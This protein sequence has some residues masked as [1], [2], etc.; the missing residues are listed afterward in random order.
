ME[1]YLPLMSDN[2]DQSDLDTVIEFLKGMPRLTQG[3]NVQAFEREWS[4]WLGVEHS[5]FVNSGSSANLLTMAALKEIYGPGEVIVPPLTWNSD[6]CSVMYAGHTPVFADINWRTLALDTDR[7]LEKITDRTRAVFITHVLGYNGLTDRLVQELRAR[8]IPLIEDVCE[9][10]GATFK[11]K[12]LGTYGLASNFSYYFAHHM[13]TIE[14][15]MI[16]TDDKR[17][18][19]V[20]RSLRGHG[21]VRE[22]TDP[23]MKESYKAEF[24]D[25]NPDFIFAYPAYNCRSTEINAVIGR[26]QLKRLDQNNLRRT[27]NFNRFIR[28]LDKDAYYTD[29]DSEGSVNYAFTLVLRKPD[30]ALW[31]RIESAL[32]GNGIEFRRGLSGGGNQLRQPY[33]RR[34]L[35]P[36]EHAKHPVVEHMH[37]YSCYIGNYPGLEPEKIDKL[38]SI[39]NDCV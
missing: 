6:V 39:L 2:I 30:G 34:I 31:S 16:C 17:F 26:N 35:P 13:S 37:F 32:R 36:N 1:F 29:F 21:M 10:H 15:G 24:P 22:M 23:A 33:L 27:E 12:R 20:V 5:V 7:V 3:A 11:G 14:G 8:K 9:S 19:E 4:K 38:C 28:Q 25:L 18:Y